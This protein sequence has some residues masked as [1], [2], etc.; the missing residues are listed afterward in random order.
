MEFNLK[1][2]TGYSIEFIMDESAVVSEAKV[3]QPNGVFT[4]KK[5]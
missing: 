3:T 4:A 5:K 2:L 1:N